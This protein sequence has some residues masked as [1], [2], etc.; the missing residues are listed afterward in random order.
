[1]MNEIQIFESPEFGRIRTVMGE[2]GEP[3]FCLADVCKM[4]GLKS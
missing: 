2:K 1:M 3:L 4:L